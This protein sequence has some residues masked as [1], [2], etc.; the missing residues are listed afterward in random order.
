[1][2]ELSKEDGGESGIVRIYNCKSRHKTAHGRIWRK[3]V[4][5]G[6]NAGAV[7][8]GISPG[9]VIIGISDDAVTVGINVDVGTTCLGSVWPTGVDTGTICLGVGF[10][11]GKKFCRDAWPVKNAV[12]ATRPAIIVNTAAAASNTFFIEY[13]PYLSTT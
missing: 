9:A 11:A 5:V 7:I 10:G 13:S 8:I 3:G 2:V 6:V 4:A 12:T 1:V